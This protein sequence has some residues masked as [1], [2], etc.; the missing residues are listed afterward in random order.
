[1]SKRSDAELEHQPRR[2]AKTAQ[3]NPDFPKRFGGWILERG[4]DLVW[5]FV[6]LKVWGIAESRSGHEGRATVCDVAG[7][8]LRGLE[9]TKKTIG[10]I[11]NNTT[12]RE[13]D[14]L[15]YF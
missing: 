8:Y 14:P 4:G 6:V 11:F 15:S 9:N 2:Q 3:P 10:P 1:V 13:H 12:D 5:G 7:L